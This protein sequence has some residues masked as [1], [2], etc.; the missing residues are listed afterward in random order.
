MDIRDLSS[1]EAQEKTRQ[2]KEQFRLGVPVDERSVRKEILESWQRSRSYGLDFETADKSLISPAALKKRIRERQVLYDIA[3][4]VIDKLYDFTTGSGFLSILCD[5]EGYVLKTIGD[6]EIR[7]AAQKNLLVEGCNRSERRIGTNGIGTPLV[8]H[9]PIQVFGE[10]HFHSPHNNRVCSGAPIFGPGGVPIGV[11]CLTGRSETVS[12]H[13][14][15]LA[16]SVAN[17]ISQQIRM[18]QAYN[19]VDRLQK[20]AELIV[21]TVPSGILLMNKDLEIIRTNSRGAALLHKPQNEIMGKKLHEILH[22]EPFSPD[23]LEETI[24][25]QKVCIE[26]GGRKTNFIFTLNAASKDHYVVTF[27]KTES[28][29]KKIHRLIGS[30]A[31]FTF[32]DII[33]RSSGIQ[34]AIALAKIASGNRS[35]VLLTGESGTGKE[36]F[37]QAIH[38]AGPRRDAPFVVLNC[39]A[40]PKSLIESELFGYENGA[41]TGARREGYAG[42]FE[43]ANGGTIFLDEIGDMPLDVQASL[44]R[45][46]QNREVSRIGSTRAT[47]LDVRI[48]AATNINLPES[49]KNN[50]FRGDLYYRLNVFNIHIPPLRER[51]ADIR[52]LAEYF[53]H[54]YAEF[55]SRPVRGFSEEA[56][57]ALEGHSWYGN[58]RELENI[59]ERAIYVA[60]SE[61]L[62]VEEIHLVSNFPSTDHVETVPSPKP[63]PVSS[64]S[65]DFMGFS[66]QGG[67]DLPSLF[68]AEDPLAA[69]EYALTAANG[70]I[71]RAA[72]MLC[73]NRR[74]LYRKLHSYGLDP[75]QLRRQAKRKKSS[76]GALP[77]VPNSLNK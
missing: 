66:P 75:K 37:A 34:N 50:A 31:Y 43:L 39:A 8:T 25:D 10:E 32:D 23:N 15:G 17:D 72:E 4:P 67:L 77:G 63:A 59:I 24:D 45:V 18:L 57:R 35:T 46:L 40:L 41:F 30:E 1:P 70:N 28:L 26:E 62:T 20:Q 36:L 73:A 6:D 27:V 61:F 65:P 11:F 2:A 19:T 53:L 29:Q 16:V 13:T 21:E 5:E 33:G 74:T 42:K 52:A 9:T 38:N 69:I 60:R 64:A 58:I 12:F 49:I 47:K 76:G 55:S 7:A 48:I 44:L 54:K 14:L 68:E 51:P 22:R 71:S 3:A 56:F